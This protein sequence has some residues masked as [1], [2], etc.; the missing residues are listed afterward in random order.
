MS[1]IYLG[2][3][4]QDTQQGFNLL[5]ANR[6]SEMCYR[7]ISIFAGPQEFS[8]LYGSEKKKFRFRSESI[9]QYFIRA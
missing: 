1:V 9:S 7:W 8:S 5:N 3:T 2:K 4:L 6:F